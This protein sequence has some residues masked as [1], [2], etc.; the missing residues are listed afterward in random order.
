[1]YT[2]LTLKHSNTAKKQEKNTP[3]PTV[4]ALYA[5][6]SL[7]ASFRL[8]TSRWLFAFSKMTTA[9]LKTFKIEFI[10]GK[11][12]VGITSMK[13][14]WMMTIIKS[15][16]RWYS[17]LIIGS[18]RGLRK[19]KTVIAIEMLYALVTIRFGFW[20]KVLWTPIRAPYRETVGSVK[21]QAMISKLI[22][23]DE[24]VNRIASPRFWTTKWSLLITTTKYRVS[25]CVLTQN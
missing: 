10:T 15:E 12:K 7:I 20:T 21:Y 25:A 18:I 22:D 2:Y 5:T 13:R 9:L 3:T 19:D 4:C 11:T 6:V 24:A 17:A 8:S 14:T 16:N 1:M 23:Q